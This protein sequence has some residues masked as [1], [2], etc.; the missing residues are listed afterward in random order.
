MKL[1]RKIYT[2][3]VLTDS[4]DRMTSDLKKWGEYS[5]D[6]D[7]DYLPSCHVKAVRTGLLHPRS[8]GCPSS[9]EDKVQISLWCLQRRRR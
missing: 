2:L 7:S 1:K 8:P 9:K 5:L 6:Y 3:I 4:S